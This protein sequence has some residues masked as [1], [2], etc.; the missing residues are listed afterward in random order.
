MLPGENSSEN[1]PITP[2]LELEFGEE[3][4]PKQNSSVIRVVQ[5]TAWWIVFRVDWK[6]IDF[7][8]SL[9]RKGTR[10]LGMYPHF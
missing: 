7:E 8:N 9:A 5:E 1:N 10:F 4:E 3:N 2:S 6:N